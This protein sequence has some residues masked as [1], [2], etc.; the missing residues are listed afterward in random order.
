MEYFCDNTR[1]ML[2]SI[3]LEIWSEHILIACVCCMECS[4]ICSL[5]EFASCLPDI[6]TAVKSSQKYSNTVFSHDLI[7]I[8][9]TEQVYF[10][11]RLFFHRTYQKNSVIKLVMNVLNFRMISLDEQIFVYQVHSELLNAGVHVICIFQ[12]IKVLSNFYM[13]SGYLASQIV[14]QLYLYCS[15]SSLKHLG[16][17]QNK[18]RKRLVPNIYHVLY[19]L[20]L[21]NS[22][23][24]NGKIIKLPIML[25]N[26]CLILSMFHNEKD[27]AFTSP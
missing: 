10:K 12:N 13:V 22:D 5:C 1:L 19:S 7:K 18:S 11:E 6:C 23:F 16:C 14:D 15:M 26:I 17:R 8:S 20:L 4:W 2:R 3:F 9:P 24:M 21:T 27:C 25:V